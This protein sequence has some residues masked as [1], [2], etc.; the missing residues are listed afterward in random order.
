M[1]KIICT[2]GECMERLLELDELYTKLY[3]VS[4][5]TA[6]QLLDMFLAGYTMR[7]TKYPLTLSELFLE[8]K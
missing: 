7:P 1:K 8:D 3:I 4:G 5:Y 2:I 6:E